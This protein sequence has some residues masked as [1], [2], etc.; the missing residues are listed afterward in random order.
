MKFKAK[1]ESDKRI[2]MAKLMASQW[3]LANLKERKP[4][5]LMRAFGVTFQ[6]A[7]AILKDERNGRDRRRAL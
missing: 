7:E 6:Q 3:T 1:V 2:A 4:E 5:D